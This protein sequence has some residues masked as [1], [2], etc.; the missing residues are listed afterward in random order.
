MVGIGSFNNGQAILNRGLIWWPLDW[1]LCCTGKCQV[2]VRIVQNTSLFG[3]V[4]QT[5]LNLQ[6]MVCGL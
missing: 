3:E 1:E 4:K 6:Q 2:F 5:V